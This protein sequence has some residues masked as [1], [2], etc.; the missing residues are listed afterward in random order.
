M[1]A[2]PTLRIQRTDSPDSSWRIAALAFGFG[3]TRFGR[4]RKLHG[5]ALSAL[6]CLGARGVQV[7][8]IDC[9]SWA[10]LRPIIEIRIPFTPGNLP[11]PLSAKSS[12]FCADVLHRV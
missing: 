9:P 6:R 1:G 2:R 8:L 11:S 3:L 5:V 7:S 10:N 4:L 12:Y